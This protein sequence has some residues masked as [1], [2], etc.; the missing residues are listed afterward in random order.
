MA[1]NSEVIIGNG[2]TAF[3]GPDAVR[4]IAAMQLRMA[5]QMYV[6]TGLLPT[7][8]VS[9]TDLLRLA[10]GYTGHAYK[11]GQHGEAARDVNTWIQT[12][13]T[14]LPIRDERTPTG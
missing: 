8:G 11:R 5:L 12:M 14:A 6:R 13:K 9:A 7:R 1:D 10:T 3:V 2:G 4:L